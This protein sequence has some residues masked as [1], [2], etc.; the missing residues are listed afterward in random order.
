MSNVD[1]INILELIV[2]S[3]LQVVIVNKESEPISFGS[4]CIIN[5]KNKF[6]WLS[7]SHVADVEGCS[8]TIES[9]ID[10][11]PVLLPIGDIYTF[12]FFKI[13]DG[14]TIKSLEE[15]FGGGKRLDICF[16]ELKQ[17]IPL[18]QKKIDFG[19]FKVEE[20]YKTI[21]YVD[22]SVELTD[23]NRYGFFGRT[24]HKY[25]GV[26]YNTVPE[27]YM[28]N[29][30]HFGL[31]YSSSNQYVDRF[32][33]PKTISDVE[34]FKG[35]SGAPILDQNGCLV[36]LVCSVYSNTKVVCGFPIKECLKLIDTVIEIDK[37]NN[38]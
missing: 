35:C 7:V 5:Y 22:Y 6:F 1:G 9:Y 29:S 13:A 36:G 28:E 34:A 17:E 31:K 26:S 16:A 38:A 23:E 15:L 24:R 12:D 37:I 18:C 25:T 33:M 19:D 4:G 30:F 2:R 11:K 21:L 3:S 8:V 10:N 14:E 32:L 20:G 27:L